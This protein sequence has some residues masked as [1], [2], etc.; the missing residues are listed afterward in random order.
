MENEPDPVNPPER[1]GR[2]RRFAAY[3][4]RHPVMIVFV[5]LGCYAAVVA[6]SEV[7]WDVIVP[8]ARAHGIPLLPAKDPS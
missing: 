5:I 4:E 7:Y 3:F 6:I 1:P 2:L 8:V